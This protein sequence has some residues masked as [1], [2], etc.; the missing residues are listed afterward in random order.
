M[1]QHGRSNP[2]RQSWNG[3][4][5]RFVQLDLANILPADPDRTALKNLDP[6]IPAF[7][8][9]PDPAVRF[10]TRK[11]SPMAPSRT[12]FFTLR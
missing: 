8:A 2:N 11:G 4:D 9:G 6:A 7:F 5:D 12:A 3:G 10:S 1:E